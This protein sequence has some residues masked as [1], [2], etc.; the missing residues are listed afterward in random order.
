VLHL[1]EDTTMTTSSTTQRSGAQA[2]SAV[3]PQQDVPRVRTAAPA[4]LAAVEALLT[5]SGLPL[6]GVKDAL[7]TFVVAEQGTD[8]VGVAGLEVCCDNALLR[9]VAVRPEWRSHGVGRALVTR[10]IS[11]AES[12]GIHA[13]Y[14]LT[15]TADR[16]FPSFGFRTIARDDVPA[17]VRETAEF[18]EACPASATV[19]CRECAGARVRDSLPPARDS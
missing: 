7:A 12:R 11:D 14:L 1:T 18:R 16:Y 15:T 2:E 19:M 13:L 3:S 10:V 17:D 9:S 4:D 5:A 8:L 6:D